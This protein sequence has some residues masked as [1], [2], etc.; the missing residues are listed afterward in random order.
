MVLK[1][2]SLPALH[3]RRRLRIELVGLELLARSR[4]ISA[5]LRAKQVVNLAIPCRSHRSESVALSSI[6][7]TQ[8]IV[9]NHTVII[10]NASLLHHVLQHLDQRQVVVRA[11]LELPV[12]HFGPRG[13]MTLLHRCTF[14][15]GQRVSLFLYGVALCE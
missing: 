4:R 11:L 5:N 15:L 8:L 9:V 3:V 2:A 10:H 12:L 1:R 7:R 14:S 6:A 13:S